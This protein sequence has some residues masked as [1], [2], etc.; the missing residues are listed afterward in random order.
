[1][2]TVCLSSLH[3]ILMTCTNETRHGSLHM[4]LH[5]TCNS[6]HPVLVNCVECASHKGKSSLTSKNKF[7]VMWTTQ[8]TA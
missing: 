3:C 5:K 2:S 7:T 4:P 1:M 8:N 6:S